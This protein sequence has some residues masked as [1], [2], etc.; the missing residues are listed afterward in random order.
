MIRI[1]IIQDTRREKKDNKYPVKLRVTY[2]REAKYYPTNID[3][4]KDEFKNVGD[5]KTIDALL[6]VKADINEM[7]TNA[8][9]IIK[10]LR[11][12]S[13]AG[14]EKKFTDFLVQQSNKK[15]E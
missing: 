15:V 14:F 12:F 7:G 8:N 11:P 6:E 2:N 1:A 4:T 13:F 5:K 9:A 3:L 10:T